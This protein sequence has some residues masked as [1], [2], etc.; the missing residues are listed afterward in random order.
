MYAIY[1]EGK[2]PFRPFTIHIQTEAE[3]LHLWHVL[4]CP[5]HQPMNDYCDKAG[6]EH[7]STPVQDNWWRM[8]D[9]KY[10]PPE[11]KKGEK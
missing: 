7:F 1:E 2:A 3:A 8:V 10:S 9:G 6:I 5:Y 4:N 11:Y